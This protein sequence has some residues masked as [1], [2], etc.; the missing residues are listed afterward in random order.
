MLKK[1]F[2]I[3]AWFLGVIVLLLGVIYL[4]A[5]KSPSYFPV[6]ECSNPAIVPFSKYDAISD[7]P[8]PLILEKNNLVVF[9]A[10]HTR[11]PKDPQIAEIDFKWKKLNP[12]IALVEGRL[13][14]LLPGFMDPVKTLGEGGKVKALANKT[15]VPLYNW[16]LSKEELAK[17]LSATFSAEQIALAQI[18]SPYFSSLRFGKPASPDKYIEEYLGRAKYV[19]LHEQFRSAADVDKAWKKHFPEGPDW[20]N[21]SDEYEM[22]GYLSNY[23]AAINDLRNKQLVCAIRELLSK[24]ERVFVICGSSH[25]ACIQPAVF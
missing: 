17:K 3:T 6:A 24:G 1:I 19:G 5:W 2:K 22:P 20:R 13:D 23:L 18:L 15:G 12:T 16:D 21:V 10:T 25:A 4:V 11:D 7:H 9:G 8:R 14:F